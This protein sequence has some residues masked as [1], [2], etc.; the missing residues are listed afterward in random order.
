MVERGVNDPV[1][2]LGSSAQALQVF[3]ITP[4][5]LGAAGEKGLGSRIGASKT[6][7]MMT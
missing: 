6:E 5:H 7:H 4:M 3:K 2:H 1:R